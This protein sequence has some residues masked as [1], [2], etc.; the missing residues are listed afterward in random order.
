MQEVSNHDTEV[1]SAIRARLHAMLGEDRGSLWFGRIT[2]RVTDATLCIVAPNAF[3]L[4]FVRK[5]LRHELEQVASAVLGESASLEYRVDKASHSAHRPDVDSTPREEQKDASDRVAA[6]TTRDELLNSG[7]RT[8]GRMSGVPD[9]VLSRPNNNPQQDNR[10]PHD[11]SPRGDKLA[12]R[13][14]FRKLDTIAQGACN[15]MALTAIEMVLREPGKMSPLLLHG[16]TG[17]GKTHLLEGMWVA[18]RKRYRSC[19]AVYLTSEQFT[20]YFLDGLRVKGLPSF[21][22]KYRDV[23]LI[24]IDDIQFFIGKHATLIEALYTIDTLNRQGRQVVLSSDRSLA[25]L[26]ELGPEFRT[27]VA[28]GLTCALQPLDHSVRRAIWRR[29]CRERGL[30]ISHEGLRLLVD[31]TAGDGRH[32]TGI[33]NQLLTHAATTSTSRP[34]GTMCDETVRKVIDSTYGAQSRLVALHEIEQVVCDLFGLDCQTLRSS[35]RTKKLARPRMVAM[36]LARKYTQAG[37]SEISEHFGRRSHTTVLSAQKR[38]ESWLADNE[39]VNLPGNAAPI[40]DLITQ[41]EWRLRAG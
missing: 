13:R 23:D 39:P 36:W 29:L 31:Q 41:L 9:A 15:E 40:R 28:G 20:Q 22:R 25:E 12:I 10:L 34:N 35:A 16:P 30:N 37:L 38:V 33:A 3:S 1:V 14:K 11:N 17:S 2:F 5:N 18:F 21:R 27:R 24:L 7:R 32:I 26:A 19:R 6:A 8:G 4:D